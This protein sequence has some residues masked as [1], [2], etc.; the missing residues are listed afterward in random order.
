MGDCGRSIIFNVNFIL[1]KPL[2]SG[3]Y[4]EGEKARYF[5]KRFMIDH[6]EK[7]VKFISDHPKS[8]LEIVAMDYR[9]NAEVV[10]SKR[11]LAP[12]K[13]DFETFIAVK[14]IKAIG[15]QLTTEKIK[16]INLLDPNPYEPPV[17][18]EVEVIEEEKHPIGKEDAQQTLF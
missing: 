7:E 12:L 11:S 18:D 4:F 1:L 13:V 15:N 3:F 8:Q 16:H 6:P 5:V 9:P 2:Q 17:L 10:F 14:G